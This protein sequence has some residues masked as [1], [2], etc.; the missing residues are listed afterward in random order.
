MS[1]SIRSTLPV[2]P[3][4]WLAVLALVAYSAACV[5]PVQ[6]QATAW[7]THAIRLIVPFPPAGGTDIVARTLAPHLSAALGQPLVID[8]K[9]GAGGTLGSELAA[10]APADGYTLLMATSSTHAVAPGLNPQLSYAPLR[11][12]APVVNV[13]VGPNILVVT[14]SLP[15]RSVR[16]LIALARSQPGKLTFASSG[17]GTVYHLSGEMFRSLAGLE[18]THVPY[19]G[20][21]LAYSD[22][23]SGQVA[24]MFDATTSVMPHVRSGKLRALAITSTRRNPGLPDLPTMGEAGVAGYESTLWIG[25]F[26]PAGTPRDIVLRLNGETN[27]VLQRTDVRETFAQQGTEAVGGTPES[28]AAQ[29][30]ADGLRWGKVIRDAGVQMD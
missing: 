13:N 6:A 14:S 18:I 29:I 4:K 28:F 5:S 9:P 30:R 27:R 23:I 16:E 2:T 3:S 11:D 22:L 12:F 20:S 25:L 7:P 26:A 8:N 15:V 10:R 1:R 19:K 21:G 17:T 24:M